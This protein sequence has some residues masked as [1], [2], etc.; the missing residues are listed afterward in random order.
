MYLWLALPDGVPSRAFA[1]RLMDEEAVI[2]IA[3][4]SFGAG[5]E[6]FVRV[7][8]IAAP[9]RLREAADRAGARAGGDAGG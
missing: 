9:E 6:G 2:T 8:L 7:S 5:G 3:G 1:E 4:A